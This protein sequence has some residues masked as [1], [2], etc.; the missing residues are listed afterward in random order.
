M[1]KKLKS[2]SPCEIMSC[3]LKHHKMSP[4]AAKTQENSDICCSRNQ[5]LFATH[6]LSSA[7][8][9]ACSAAA[10]RR[11]RRRPCPLCHPPGEGCD[12]LFC[13]PNFPFPS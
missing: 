1:I 6:R 4:D 10:A 8:S 13:S 12:Q 9:A 11:R 5:S 2:F 7:A 3:S